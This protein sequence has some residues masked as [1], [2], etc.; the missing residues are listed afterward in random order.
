MSGLDK[1]LQYIEDEAKASANEMLTKANKKAGEIVAA[2]QAEA[3]KKQR[4]IMQDSELKIK[5]A[6]S[7]AESAA[8]LQE[9][10]LILQ[11][12]QEIIK[13]VINR[14]MN[15]LLVLSDEAYF[16][17]IKKMIQKYAIAESGQIIV[18]QKDKARIPTLFESSL[19]AILPQGGSLTV[20]NET[21][22]FS[23]GFI[24]VYGDIEVNCTFEA[25]FA[26]A[27]DVLQD[28]VSSLLFD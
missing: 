23:G 13:D 6:V 28:K 25:I 18:N 22:N 15:S 12:K 3:E 9:R 5:D 8:L 7:R 1:I 2:A 21:R 26:A 17:A 4:S 10:K 27:K 11:A 14:S 24:L 19:Q 16:E 20:S